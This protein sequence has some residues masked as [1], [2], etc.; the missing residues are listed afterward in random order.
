MDTM[1]SDGRERFIKSVRLAVI[2]L[3]IGGCAILPW[4]TN[5]N[6]ES[7]EEQLAVGHGDIPTSDNLCKLFASQSRS[8]EDLLKFKVNRHTPARHLIEEDINDGVFV[9]IALSGGGSRAANFSAAVLLELQD[10]G[11]FPAHVTTLSSV[12][13]GSLTSAY[14]KLFSGRPIYWNEKIIRKR[15]I[16]DLE[17]PWIR[18]MIAPHHF[19]R[20]LFT[21]YSRSDVMAGVLDDYLFSTSQDSMLF[22]SLKRF[23]QLVS[24]G[25]KLYINASVRGAG[26]KIFPFLDETFHA[27]GSRLDTYPLAY[28]VMA[29]GAFPGAFNDITIR[30]YYFE[31]QK[32]KASYLH[33]YDGGPTDN[34][35]ITTLLKE[36]ENLKELNP[37]AIKAC[38]LFVIDAHI[39][40]EP[41]DSLRLSER[42]TRKVINFVIDR[43]ALDAGDVLLARARWATLREVFSNNNS[44]E[45]P[46]STAKIGGDPKRPQTQLE[47]TIWHIHFNRLNNPSMTGQNI[48]RLRKDGE[49]QGK[50]A[51]HNYEKLADLLNRVETRYALTVSTG[52]ES[53]HEIQDALFRAAK[54]LVWQD[55]SSL[56]EACSW[57]KKQQI[58]LKGCVVSP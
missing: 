52:D 21:D 41:T 46:I 25:P 54:I 13:G 31:N 39:H 28:S 43:N 42:T 29:S 10:L 47:C 7:E 26:C 24:E 44:W 4:S 15:F 18:R 12:S 14:Y 32:N 50:R 40:G 1:K 16:T 17:W 37:N 27:M 53:A 9:G 56:S 19:I 30:D 11:L 48:H 23:D 55:K 51:V 20:T 35:G 5:Q 58:D 6:V 57:F 49:E 36:A 33:L 8:A 3:M 45:S 38:F 2:V 34:L 22:A